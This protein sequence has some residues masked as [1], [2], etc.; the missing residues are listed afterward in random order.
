MRDI[1]SPLYIPVNEYKP[2]G[3]RIG[4]VDGPFE[5]VSALGVKL[6]WPFTTRTP[7]VLPS[8]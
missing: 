7:T 3:P 1:P 5:Y 2:F 6:R 8:G 4:V